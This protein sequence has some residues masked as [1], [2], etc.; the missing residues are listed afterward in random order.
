MPTIE[1]MQ[2]MRDDLVR[3]IHDADARACLVVT[4]GG[5][6]ALNALFAVPGASR[7]VIDAQIPYAR[8]SLDD[9]LGAQAARHVSSG[10]A[11]MMAR[12]AQVRAVRLDSERDPPSARIV[13][14]SCTAA[15][16][17]DRNR[18]GENRCHVAWFD[19][20]TGVAHTLTLEKGARDRVGEESMCAVMILN[21]LAEACGLDA[22][23][24]LDLL[25]SERLVVERV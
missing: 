6:S 14:L 15:I 7:T 18:R 23:L 9:Y 4:G 13:G 11:T 24:P 19:G 10:E 17:T 22:R 16:A 5:V 25:E 3:A 12:A 21:A 1:L 20:T 8:A 2:S